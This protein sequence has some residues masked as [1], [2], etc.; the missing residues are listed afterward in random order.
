MASVVKIGI[1]A[2]DDGFKQSLSQ[3]AQSAAAF[4]K[5]I[6]AS[7]KGVQSLNG[8]MRT[9]KKAVMDLTFAYQQLDAEAKNSEFG[10]A[11]KAQLE[12]A[13]QAAAELIDMRSDVSQELKNMASDTASW[14][15]AKEGIGVLTSGMQGFAGVVGLCGGDVTA[16]TQ[17]L[18]TMNTIAAISNSII[19]IGNA[20]QAES[21]LMTGLRAAKNAILT[22]SLTANTAAQTA[23]TGAIGAATT[24]QIA[25][26]AAVMANPYILAAAAIA[27]LVAGIA[28]WVSNMDEATDSQLALNAATEA[29][30][31][32]LDST[33]KT[34]AEQISTFMT[35]KK[36]YDECGNKTDELKKKIIDNTE[37][38]RKLG[39]T[40]KT[41]DDVHRLFGK[42]SNDYI[43]YCNARA[44]AMAAEAAQ[45][46]ILGKVLSELSKIQQKIAR[47][48]EVDY[49][50]FEKI[51]TGAG[52]SKSKINNL[53]KEAGGGIEW[54]YIWENLDA[55]NM[56]W[57]KFMTD[58]ASAIITEG[59]GKVLQDVMNS[60]QTVMTEASESWDDLLEKNDKGTTKAGNK[61]KQAAKNTADGVKEILTSL[62]GC[63]A[64][65]Q[66]AE[67]DMKKLDSNS[68]D[69][70]EK[71]KKLKDTILTARAAKL[72]L[73]DQTTLE[74]LKESKSL[75]EKIITSLPE[76]ATGLE[77]WQEALKEVNERILGIMENVAKSGDIKSMNEAKSQI[78]AI[79][80]SLPE[81]SKELN[82]WIEKWQA[83]NNK[84]VEAEKTVSDLKAGVQKGSETW[85]KREISDINTQLENLSP[86]IEGNILLR[87]N[88]E[89][90][91]S[92]LEFQLNRIKKMKDPIE[93]VGKVNLELDKSYKLTPLERLQQQ[94]EKLEKQKEKLKDQ[95]ELAS[96]QEEYDDLAHKIAEVTVS[97]TKLK[98]EMNLKE[99]TD[100]IK[101][102]KSE[103]ASGSYEAFKS[104]I[105]GI[106]S[107]Y[108]S[109]SDLV[110]KLDECENAAE[111][112]FA[113]FDT[114]FTVIDN[115]KGMYDSINALVEII[116]ILKG[117]ETAYQA[118]NTVTTTLA[119]QQAGALIGQGVAAG[120]AMTAEQTKAAIDTET[121]GTA[122]AATAALKG[123]EAAYLDM[124]A[125][126]IFAAHSSIP[127]AGVGIAS[128]LVSA[129]MG[130]M[131]AQHAASLA[132]STFAE[133]GIVGGS[134][135]IGD[136]EIVRVNKRE[137]ILNTTQQ[138]RLFNFIDHGQL[139]ANG[140]PNISTVKIKGDD[141]YIQMH[142]YYKRTKKSPFE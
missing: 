71:M 141:M 86:D 17:A 50:D 69:Y 40:V 74:G 106:E 108:N 110:G 36:T 20:L 10:I 19:S 137:M 55:S 109:V 49:T 82:V 125:A 90:K 58:A 8:A 21:A 132:L 130:A 45:A 67:K 139:Y 123:E 63:D 116:N 119:G 95:Q 120:E 127:F 99:V 107:M 75:I 4:A 128:G 140:E 83:I 73:L 43:R 47:G 27:A 33:M 97:M 59:A 142:N 3:M 88:L 61:G 66:H 126:A 30:E 91:K 124:A 44:T 98:R 65:I 77:S 28:I 24:A 68:T 56:D 54:D 18:A 72:K 89:L 103:L 14:D 135:T 25:N 41:V 46:A 48:E 29:M 35:L 113:V 22:G 26:N 134:T 31:E 115:I 7:G 93:V 96:S 39:V 38:Q 42:H 52:L 131:A 87:A 92:D 13:K 94:Y 2:Q 79:I 37:A 6:G 111:G 57:G 76:G 129:M 112:L 81:G 101:E 23:N 121:A 80:L 12:E 11:L 78:E 9:A 105:S 62:E 60:S 1:T 100:D 70:V 15:A 133:G 84:I 5:D 32:E 102:Y 53:V 34:A 104:G 16:F 51:L 138:N 85:L 118:V 122:L 114:I 136:N 117:A 64:I